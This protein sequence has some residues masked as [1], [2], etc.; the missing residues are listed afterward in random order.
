MKKTIRNL[1]IGTFALATAALAVPQNALAGTF[2]NLVYQSQQ[3]W[4]YHGSV[5]ALVWTGIRS[6]RLTTYTSV[7]NA[8]DAW[9]YTNCTSQPLK[10]LGGRYS[11]GNAVRVEYYCPGSTSLSNAQGYINDN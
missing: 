3:T 2:S 6:S 5:S 4:F 9:L 8:H 7:G 1:A 10:I 11:G